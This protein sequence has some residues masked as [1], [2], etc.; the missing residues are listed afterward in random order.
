MP[1]SLCK[2][3][4]DSVLPIGSWRASQSRVGRRWILEEEP[5]ASLGP[6]DQG[7]EFTPT[8]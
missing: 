4:R 7:Q 1:F 6:D 8:R 5:A 2:S 3:A